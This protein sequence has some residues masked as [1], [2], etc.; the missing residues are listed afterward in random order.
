MTQPI[1]SVFLVRDYDYD[2]QEVVYVA[3]SRES[4]DAYIASVLAKWCV[5]GDQHREEWPAEE[6]SALGAKHVK[7]RLSIEEWPLDSERPT[8]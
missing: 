4:A 1:I 5:H 7:E 6:C 3:A 2:L 8:S